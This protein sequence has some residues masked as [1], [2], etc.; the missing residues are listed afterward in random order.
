MGG[1]GVAPVFGAGQAGGGVMAGSAGRVLWMKST[2]KGA[3][4]SSPAKIVP[5]LRRQM[6]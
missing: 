3:A 4:L 1:Y 5:F 6:G 2:A